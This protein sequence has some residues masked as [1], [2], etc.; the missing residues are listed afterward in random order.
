M[1]ETL[2]KL[3]FPSE[4]EKKQEYKARIEHLRSSVSSA[5]EE[6]DILKQEPKATL[7]DLMR[8]NMALLPHSFTST[9]D[10]SNPFE[11]L[12]KET[13]DIKVHELNMVFHNAAFNQLLEYLTNKQFHYTM[14]RATSDAEIYA[15][16]FNI[17]GLALIKSNLN[18]YHNIYE[19]AIKPPDSYDEHEIIS[20]LNN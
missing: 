5:E 7:A 14:T 15:G 17:N 12:N 20:E 2:F 6:N 8:E 16:R 1:K 10:P 13:Y 19:E 9:D 18:K 3:L 11:G 4:Y